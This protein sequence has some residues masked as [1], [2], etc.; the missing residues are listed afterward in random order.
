M[1][2]LALVSLLLKY[3]LETSSDS[4]QSYVLLMKLFVVFVEAP[5]FLLVFLILNT[6]LGRFFLFYNTGYISL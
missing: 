5:S 3:F 4:A 2:E 1:V 6:I